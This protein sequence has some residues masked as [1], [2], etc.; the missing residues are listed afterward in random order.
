MKT[1]IE[2]I[3]QELKNLPQWVC[4]VGHDKI[5]KN[6]KTGGN[7]MANNPDTWGTYEQAVNACEKYGFDYLGFEFA[8]GYFGVDLPLS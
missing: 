5:P 8:N 6:P 2:N 7:A 1:K 4:A 3:P